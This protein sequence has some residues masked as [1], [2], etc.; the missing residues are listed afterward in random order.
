MSLQGLEGLL[1]GSGEESATR[2]LP[3]SGAQRMALAAAET[4]E[5]SSPDDEHVSPPQIRHP[6]LTK[7]PSSSGRFWF[8]RQTSSTL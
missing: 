1:G 8:P 3:P 7:Q 6:A 4:A 5:E 2:Q